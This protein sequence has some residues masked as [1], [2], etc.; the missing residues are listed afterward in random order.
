MKLQPQKI[1]Y[2]AVKNCKTLSDFFKPESADE[3]EEC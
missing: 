3:E 2:E 1:S